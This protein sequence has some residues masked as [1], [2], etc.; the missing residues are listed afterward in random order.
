MFHDNKANRLRKEILARVARAF[1]AEQPDDTL[2]RIP[3]SMRPKEAKDSSRCCIYK[4]RAVVKYRTMAALGYSVENETDELKPISA[5]FEDALQRPK[6]A[7]PVLTVIDVACSACVTTQYSA[8]NACK[9]CLARSCETVCPKGAIEP[10]EGKAWINPAK[11]V[12]CGLCMKA[13]PY[14]AIIRIPIPCEEACPVGAITKDPDTGRETIDHTRCTYCGKCLRECPFAAITDL[15]QMI[16]VLKTLG[17]R[18]TVAMIAPSIA[19]QL[20]GTLPQLI[21]ALKAIGFADVVEVAVGADETAVHE[22]AEWKEKT[23][24][25]DRFMTT[26][27]CPAYIETV[28]KHLPDLKPFVSNTPTPMAYTAAAVRKINPDAVTVFIGPCIAKRVEAQKNDTVDF[29]LTFE[30]LGAILVGAGIDVQECQE[31]PAKIAP[32]REGR[33]FAASRGVTAAVQA[34]LPNG[35]PI[36]PV[37]IDGI[38]KKS[39]RQMQQWATGSCPGNF[40][41]VMSCEGGCIAGPGTIGN[42]RIAHKTLRRLCDEST[43][44]T[45]NG[46]ACLI[47]I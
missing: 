28:E 13:C 47:S 25:G 2:N 6:A 23:G 10:R 24:S 39:I 26:S 21:T 43:P 31:A 33:G 34:A 41:E 3:I 36:D 12:N 29:V 14:H 45:P 9:G 15:S 19:G 18:Y 44:L 38:D 46:T 35:T 30:E 5:Y 40:V 17:S 42:P 7:A 16:D 22:S 37:Q 8:T 1:F 27:C 4:D 20:P 11:C 32:S